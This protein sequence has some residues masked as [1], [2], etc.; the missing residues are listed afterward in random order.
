[1][2]PDDG[3]VAHA[4][5]VFGP[6]IVMVSDEYPEAGIHSP[7]RSGGTPVRIQLDAPGCWTLP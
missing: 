5:L 1:M 4:E 3:R 6:A 2:A 7:T